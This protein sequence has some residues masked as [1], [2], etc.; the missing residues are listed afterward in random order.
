VTV[1]IATLGCNII[2][3]LPLDTEVKFFMLS[4]VTM[5]IVGGIAF[6]VMN[7]RFNKFVVFFIVLLFLVPFYRQVQGKLLFQED[8]LHVNELYYERGKYI[9]STS[10]EENELYQWI[11]D[12]TEKSSPFIDLQLTIPVLAQRQLFIGMDSEAPLKRAP[13]GT[14]EVF[15]G[16][17]GYTSTIDSFLRFVNCYEP[18]LIER[19]QAFVETLYGVNEK[20]T[21]EEMKSLFETHKNMYVVVRTKGMYTVIKTQGSYVMLPTN[22][23]KRRFTEKHF[24]QIFR[25][26]KGNFLVFQKENL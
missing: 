7:Q 15:G 19:R 1:V 20:L 24:T 8:D 23:I 21:T 22:T 18:D 13:M 2:F 12:H 11:R 26:S 14:K 3:S 25:S 6:H 10:V 16:V 5:G 17:A 9:H 4:T